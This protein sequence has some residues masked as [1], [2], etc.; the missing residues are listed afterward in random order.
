VPFLFYTRGW[1]Q[2]V[3]PAEHSLDAG[4]VKYNEAV[5]DKVSSLAA[6]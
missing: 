2:Y 3:E 5:M 4:R 6:V 1:K